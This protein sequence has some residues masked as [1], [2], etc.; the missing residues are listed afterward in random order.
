MMRTMVGYAWIKCRPHHKS[1]GHANPPY[2]TA[3]WAGRALAHADPTR[4]A[5]VAALA[6]RRTLQH[7][8]G[9]GRDAVLLHRDLAQHQL[10][11]GAIGR[12]PGRAHALGQY[13]G[14][15]L[16]RLDFER[17]EIKR[18]RHHAGGGRNGPDLHIA[19]IAGGLA[20]SLRQQNTRNHEG[21]HP[22][23]P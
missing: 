3:A 2:D 18:W 17:V 13:G 21:T 5:A 10:A 7:R 15:L 8:D 12:Q 9:D 11:A 23:A 4:A 20:G 19:D 1:T 16:R 6:A 22:Q 14:A